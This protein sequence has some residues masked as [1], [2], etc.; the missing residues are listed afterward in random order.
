M[1]SRGAA[2]SLSLVP[3]ASLSK[4]TLAAISAGGVLVIAL[5]VS[6]QAIAKGCSPGHAANEQD[7]WKWIA[8]NARRNADWY[9]VDRG[10]PE[11]VPALG[12]V[13]VVY[14]DDGEY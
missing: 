12:D 1:V 3:Q 11:A 6:A 4:R 9:V 14:Q 2:N 7:D 13:S 8:N 5:L 10:A